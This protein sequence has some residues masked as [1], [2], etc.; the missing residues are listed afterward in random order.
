MAI[1]KGYEKA[2]KAYIELADQGKTL[3]KSGSCSISALIVDQVCYVANVGDSRG[4]V[5]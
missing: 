1:I 4:I 3:D 2:E 5:S